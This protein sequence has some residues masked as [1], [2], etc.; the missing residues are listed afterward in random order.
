[1]FE[2]VKK[3]IWPPDP[4]Y[5]KKKKKTTP[6]LWYFINIDKEKYVKKILNRFDFNNLEYM[7]FEK[8]QVVKMGNFNLSI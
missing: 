5:L 4:L 8:L 6:T 1:M 3:H 7:I 2:A